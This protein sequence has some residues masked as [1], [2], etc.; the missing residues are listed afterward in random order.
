MMV[1][2]YRTKHS[3]PRQK[4]RER[5]SIRL[6]SD[7][8]VYTNKN[9]KRLIDSQTSHHSNDVVSSFSAFFPFPL[10]NISHSFLLFHQLIQVS[11]YTWEYQFSLVVFSFLHHIHPVEKKQNRIEYGSHSLYDR[12][13]T[14]ERAHSLNEF[15]FL[16]G[17]V[18]SW[19][20]FFSTLM[21]MV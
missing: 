13:R 16:D 7:T 4:E 19:F 6:I 12:L 3:T 8:N 1:T 15:L 21:P 18:L 11:I 2:P 10:L 20:L 5:E 17:E 9:T 14:G